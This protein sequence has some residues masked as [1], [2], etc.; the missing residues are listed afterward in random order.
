MTERPVPTTGS[1]A[2]RLV[3]TVEAA[4]AEPEALIASVSRALDAFARG[5]TTDDRAILVLHRK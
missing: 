5:T 2:A 3:A 4:P 1:G